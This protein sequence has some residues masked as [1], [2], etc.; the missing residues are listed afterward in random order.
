MRGPFEGVRAVFFDVDDTLYDFEESMRHAFHHLRGAFPD[1]LGQHDV[2]RVARAYWSH[3]R[4]YPE[5]AKVELINRDP[6]AFRRVMWAGALAALG[7]DE[8]EAALSWLRKAHPTVREPFAHPEGFA[9]VLT[10]EFS[11]SRP[12][13]WRRAMYPGAR[14][15]LADLRGRVALGAITNGP[16]PVQ[17]PKL[18]AFGYREWFPERLVFVSGEFGARK[19]DPSIFLAAARAAGVAPEEC[20]MVGDAREFDMPAKGVGFRT[21]LLCEAGRSTDVSGL[22][23]EPDLVARSYD[24]VRRALLG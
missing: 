7:C 8:D 19:P 6:E 20:V 18:E 22:E 15:L 5:E 23:H 14:E 13:H 17:R 10:E 9:R 4:A 2:D 1:V 24:D 16:G 21:I 12:E 3:Y 11:R